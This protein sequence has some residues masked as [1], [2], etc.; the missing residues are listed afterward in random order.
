MTPFARVNGHPINEADELVVGVETPQMKRVVARE[1][2]T[3]VRGAHARVTRLDRDSISCGGQVLMLAVRESE[4]S[5]R[6]FERVFEFFL[7]TGDLG[8]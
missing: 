8:D 6:S 3:T 7:R 1:V 5:D 4:I 2:V